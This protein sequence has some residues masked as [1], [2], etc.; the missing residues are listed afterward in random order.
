MHTDEG[1]IVERFLVL[2]LLLQTCTT[3][4]VTATVGSVGKTANRVASSYAVG[5]GSFVLDSTV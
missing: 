2:D 4:L 3:L 1:I 5:T